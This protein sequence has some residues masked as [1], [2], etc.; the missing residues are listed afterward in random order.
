MAALDKQTVYLAAGVLGVALVAAYFLKKG[1]AGLLSGNNP[2][3]Q[4]ATNAA[5]QSVTAYQGAGPLGTLGAA[6]NAASGG[7]LASAGQWIG[8]KVYDLTNSTPAPAPAS[9]GQG[10]AYQI[11][12]D[13][14]IT[15]PNAGW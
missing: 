9:S 3:T 8:G 7:W 13:F 5:G 12:K 2:L 10:V 4:N 6:T 11:P 15:D 1:A 14:G